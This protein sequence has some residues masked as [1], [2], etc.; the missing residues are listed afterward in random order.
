MLKWIALAVLVVGTVMVIAAVR[1]EIASIA[2]EGDLTPV[3]LGVTGVVAMVLGLLF[4][5]LFVFI[6]I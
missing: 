4:G 3:A 6:D 2:D 1:I 5:G